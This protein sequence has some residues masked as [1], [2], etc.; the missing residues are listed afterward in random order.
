MPELATRMIGDLTAEWAF[1]MRASESFSNDEIADMLNEAERLG[2][3]MTRAD[4]PLEGL[5][6]G[7]L[8]LLV[9]PAGRC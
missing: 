7:E 3:D 8:W 4:S 5:T 9:Q 2:F 6:L 1:W